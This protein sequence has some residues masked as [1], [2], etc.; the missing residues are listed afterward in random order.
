MN[1]ASKPTLGSVSKYR[2]LYINH[3]IVTYSEN[4]GDKNI[5]SVFIR[6]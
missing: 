5:G 4:T 2:K 3:I 1:S 6:L